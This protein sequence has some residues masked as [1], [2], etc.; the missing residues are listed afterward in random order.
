MAAICPTPQ[1][2]RRKRGLHLADVDLNKRR[3]LDGL[4]R[5]RALFPMLDDHTVRGVFDACANDVDAAIARLSALALASAKPPPPPAPVPDESD[6]DDAAL[7]E[8]RSPD[9]WVGAFVSEMAKSAD[10]GDARR[11]AA[12]ALRAFESFVASRT[13]QAAD[14]RVD[15]LERENAVLRKA[16]AIQS[17]RL[18][19]AADEN[20][21]LSGEAGTARDALRRAERVNY[22]LSV[23]LKHAAP[24]TPGGIGRLDVF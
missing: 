21:R 12:R 14:E 9:E 6:G 15:R 3:K 16:V 1:P 5:L 10:V 17:Q 19:A 8:A 23:Q 13:S 18:G 4:E 22:G 24:A 7:G 2:P 20:R 11:R